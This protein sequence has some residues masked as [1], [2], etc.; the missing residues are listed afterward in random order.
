MSVVAWAWGEEELGWK[1]GCG[2]YTYYLVGGEV[3]LSVCLYHNSSNCV[4][5][6]VQ[7][8]YQIYLTNVTVFKWWVCAHKIKGDSC[9]ER[10]GIRH[11]EQV[12]SN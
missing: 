8:L 10:G 11:E 3:L 9:K 1:G 5:K 6:Y 12:L 2:G 7:S 4:C